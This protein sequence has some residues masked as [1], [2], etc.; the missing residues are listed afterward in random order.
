ML[1]VLGLRV[2]AAR[3]LGFRGP[4]LEFLLLRAV[5]FLTW[6]GCPND[7]KSKRYFVAGNC[8]F[9]FGN[10]DGISRTARLGSI[11]KVNVCS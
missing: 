6:I 8:G 2:G 9:L 3:S 10:A 11:G 7:D 4:L 1:K 5:R